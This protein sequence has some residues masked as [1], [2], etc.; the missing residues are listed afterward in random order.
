MQYDVSSCLLIA[1]ALPSKETTYS[2][3]IAHICIK[4]L[5]LLRTKNVTLKDPV[6]STTIKSNLVT[7]PQAL[8][9][10]IP[11]SQIPSCLHFSHRH[12]QTAITV[13]AEKLHLTI[14]CIIIIIIIKIDY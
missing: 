8:N 1:S 5:S 14:S 11:T 9:L 6:Q 10:A 2:K 4:T 3:H 7:K 13:Q 12:I